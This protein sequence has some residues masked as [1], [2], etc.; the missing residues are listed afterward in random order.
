MKKAAKKTIISVLLLFLMQEANAMCRGE[1]IDCHIEEDRRLSKPKVSFE[2]ELSRSNLTV[3]SLIDC[4]LG[5]I[6]PGIYESSD[7]ELIINH[8]LSRLERDDLI[9]FDVDD[10][11]LKS[12]D[13]YYSEHYMKETTLHQ[14]LYSRDQNTV[15]TFLLYL[16]LSKP[17]VVMDPKLPELLNQLKLKNIK[18]IANTAILP[19]VNEKLHVD[20]SRKRLE[21]LKEIGIDFADSFSELP[22]W[23]FDSFPLEEASKVSPMFKEGVIFSSQ[24]PKYSTT[25]ALLQKLDFKP[26]R[27]AFIDDLFDNAKEMH[28]VL[29]LTGIECFSFHY[30]KKERSPVTSYFPS[31]IGA[32]ELKRI[33][34]FIE[35]L[36][37]GKNVE[38]FFLEL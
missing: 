3:T 36:L 20:I 28:D 35:T 23:N 13:P 18:H 25:L 37:S 34:F 6:T 21:T 5:T 29:S 1:S 15:E 38:E 16:F 24:A 10:V 14:M 4:S 11:L 19:I 2:E 22:F 30:T 26:K 33:E 12:L 8:L 7:I 31:E 17:C 32:S 9:I 27:I